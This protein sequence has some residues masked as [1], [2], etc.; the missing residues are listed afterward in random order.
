MCE[1]V[2]SEVR[3][4]YDDERRFELAMDALGI[5][6]V[7]MAAASAALA[8]ATFRAYR[9]RGGTRERIM[10]DFLIGAH[11][12]GHADRLLTRD[13]SFFERNFPALTLIDSSAT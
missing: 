4:G 9:R 3:A 8:G 7:P 12:L 13:A 11:A 6:F 5:S 1:A 2:W 10:A